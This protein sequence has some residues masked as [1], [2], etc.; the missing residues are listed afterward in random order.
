LSQLRFL[1]NSGWV[2]STIPG[3]SIRLVVFD[4]DGTL[5]EAESSWA[6]VNRAFG[7]DSCASMALYRTGA[8]DYPE[9]MRR[10]IASWPK[11]LRLSRVRETL[12]DWAFRPGAAEIIPALRERG[13]ELAILTGG[14]HVLAEEVAESLGIDHV[15]ANELLTDDAGF[16]TGE[17]RM[18]VDPLRKE[19][20]LAQLCRSVDV[21]PRACLT[22]GDSEMDASFLR[23]SGMGI[24]VGDAAQGD[25][26]GVASV[27]E[28]SALLDVVD[29]GIR[30][31]SGLR[32]PRAGESRR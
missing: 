27:P 10:D 24:L 16:L 13:L 5:L 28:L 9:F 17:A 30:S 1:S 29:A 23:A 32:G 20:A 12:S 21:P 11:P 14:I 8:I 2:P 6:T 4:L 26:L 31:P 7:H 18:R 3:T 25:A 22:V 19:H 15:V